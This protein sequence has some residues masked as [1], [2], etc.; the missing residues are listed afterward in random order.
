VHRLNYDYKRLG[1]SAWMKE[2]D[3]SCVVK[4]WSGAYCRGSYVGVKNATYVNTKYSAVSVVL[5]GIERSLSKKS[6]T[7]HAS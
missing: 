2:E 5:D 1:I 3:D 7:M 6:K 4:A